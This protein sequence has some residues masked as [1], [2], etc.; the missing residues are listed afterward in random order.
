MKE[1]HAARR[2]AQA[3]MRASVNAR[4]AQHR[5]LTATYLVYRRGIASKKAYRGALEKAL[6][7]GPTKPE[8]KRPF[9]HL[10][11]ALIGEYGDQKTMHGMSIYTTALEMIHQAFRKTSPNSEVI[12]GY[13][14]QAGGI[15]GLYDLSKIS[16]PLPENFDT[17]SSSQKSRASIVSISK[18]RRPN[19]INLPELGLEVTKVGRAYKLKTDWEPGEYSIIVKVNRAGFI[20]GLY[21]GIEDE[22]VA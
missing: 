17:S 14:R 21:D 18:A 15:R 5:F 11:H 10:L 9:L 8:K 7:R 2:A 20:T 4:A 12:T 3:Y 13:I 6:S 16:D 22:D 19:E 1:F